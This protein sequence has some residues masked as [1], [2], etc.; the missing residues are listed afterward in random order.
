MGLGN[1]APAKTR[2]DAHRG[3]IFASR[4]GAIRL[5]RNSCRVS[6]VLC[7]VGGGKVGIID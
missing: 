6:A 1:T 4:F 7:E 5:Q 3:P 2:R